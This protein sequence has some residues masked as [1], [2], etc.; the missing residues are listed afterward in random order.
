ML[1]LIFPF[2]QTLDYITIVLL[3]V[4]IFVAGSLFFGSGHNLRSFFAGGGNIPWWIGGLSLFMSFFSAGTFVV[5]GSIAYTEG[6]T[7]VTIQWMM[8]GGGV[9]AGLL[10][11]PRWN[12]T[13]CLT[14][15]EYIT[16]RFGARVQKF[17]TALF[18]SVSL[19]S[20]G[21]FLYSIARIV[22]TAVGI[23]FITSILVLGLLCILYVAIG[24]FRA[25]VVTDV[26]QFL[27]LTAAVVIVLP[28][29]FE[30]I[31]GTDTLF[32]Q[33]PEGFFRPAAGEYT[34]GFMLAS[35]LGNASS[36]GGN[37]AFVQ[38]YTSV[39][40]PA[41]ARKTG[42]LF[43]A[44]YLVCPV[45]WMLPPM[46]F[47][48]HEPSLTGFGSEN[49]YLL[50]CRE[51]LPPGLLG[52]MLGGMIFATLSSFNTILNTSA[53]VVTNDLLKPLLRRFPERTLM[54]AARLSTVVFGVLAVT[55]ALFIPRC[56]GIVNVVISIGAMTAAPMCLPVVWSLYSKGLSG[57]AVLG[58]T[59]A[60]LGINLAFKFAVPLLS[61]FSLSRA[62]EM[63]LGVLG[64]AVILAGH[65]V[66]R[67]FRKPAA[68]PPM[69]QRSAAPDDGS[70][71]RNN[72]FSLKVIG[73][74]AMLSGA[75][76]SALGIPAL[77]V[78]R[79]PLG[80]GLLLLAAG[81]RLYFPNR[82]I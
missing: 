37:W 72:R 35:L 15:A 33:T 20:T 44:L 56:G 77:A 82:R 66:C 4:G 2:L 42:L 64:P 40:T 7:A 71:A 29:A 45:V 54:R 24:G 32:R 78:S 13:G 6:W 27:I 9:I 39:A 5:W 49:A 59:L 36:L 53:S 46:L 25:V 75:L 8:A 65:E 26:L 3:L 58:T 1:F 76:V 60:A 61:G 22:E 19:F 81:L 11:A 38:R 21:T 63:A 48:L 10:I 34:W 14:A 67:R 41:A 12:R 31:G 51:V 62:G 74:G 30:R 55:F 79:F 17:Y 18:L 70:A 43:G 57:R 68:Q 73:V 69:P 23:S 28:L 16:R 50:M 52:L 80:I 47:R